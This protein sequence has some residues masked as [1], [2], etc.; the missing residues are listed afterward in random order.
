MKMSMSKKQIS[1]EDAFDQFIKICEVKNYSK[2]TIKTYKVHFKVFYMFLDCT[3]VID[4]TQQMVNDFV[5]YMKGRCGD[6]TINSYLRSIRSF[7]YYCMNLGYM[8]EFKIPKLRVQKTPKPVYS[9]EELRL[10]LAKPN[11][12]TCD[13]TEYRMWAFSNFLLGTGVRLSSALNVKIKDLDFQDM[14]IFITLTKNNKAQIIPMSNSLFNIL[15]EYLNYRNGKEEDYLFCN[16]FGEKGNR[17][18]YQESLNKYNASRGVSSTGSHRYR[19]TFAKNW[20]LN[21]GDMFRLQKIL[22]HS[23][24]TVVREYVEMFGDDLTMDFDKFNPLDNMTQNT[25]NRGKIKMK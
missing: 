8:E 9:K 3:S 5:L 1:I 4:I 16:S 23:D 13:F 12:K 17:R 22:G 11:I 20:I 15:Q 25:N 24:L 6:I 14:L 10:L 7:L 19:H 18:S 21:G 2:E